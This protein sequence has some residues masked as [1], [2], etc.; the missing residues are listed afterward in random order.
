MQNDRSTLSRDEW[1]LLSNIIHA[2]DATEIIPTTKQ[3]FE[4]Q[5]M[6][7]LKVRSKP[8]TALNIYR[9]FYALFIPFV[10]RTRYFHEISFETSEEL[11]QNNF[12]GFGIF[13]SGYIM[14]E[15]NG[16][17]DPLLRSGLSTFYT[18]DVESKMERF[19][20]RLESDPS[21]IKIILMILAFSPNS[22]IVSFDMS[23][24]N[25]IAGNSLTISK[26]Q[27]TIVTMFWKY[28]LY[29]YGFVAA[30]QRL[31]S[32]VKYLIDMLQTAHEQQGEQIR[33]VVHTMIDDAKQSLTIK[34]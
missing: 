30:V 31:S 4:A 18:G 16:L 1:D 11:T 20:S 14:R 10:Q 12:R 34:D 25:Y 3:L 28:L 21:L 24:R 29:K 32:H 15:L 9:R 7:P 22:S 27:D 19:V 8:T 17:H 13:H 5:L 2:Y 6:L 26:I 23:S 33:A